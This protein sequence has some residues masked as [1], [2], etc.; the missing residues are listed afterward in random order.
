MNQI[1]LKPNEKKYLRI[2]AKKH[3][4][5]PTKYKK[6]LVKGWNKFYAETK[7]IEQLLTL[8]QEYSL[9]TG[10]WAG[11]D[12]YFIAIDLDD[13][14]AKERIDVSLY[15]TT[16]KGIHRYIFIKELPKSCFLVNQDGKKLGELHSAGRFV[17]G[18]GSVHQER[19]RYT[20]RGRVNEKWSLKFDK[21]T[22]LQN[23][24]KERSIF[25]TPWGKTGKEN[26]RDLE[27]YQPKSK[28]ATSQSNFY[29][30][31]QELETKITNH[32]KA[33]ELNICYTCLVYFRKDKEIIQTH[34]AGK[35]HQKNWKNYQNKQN[36][37]TETNKI[38]NICQLNQ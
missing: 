21:L 18:I 30:Q 37:T 25:I 24:L 6:P 28:K 4:L 27:L 17:V 32:P 19:T 35:K 9:R 13:Y 33:E 3:I 16:N 23:F 31:K 20:L 36:N 14:W 26:I 12:Y 22:E 1:K 38:T 10:K 7:T 8:N 34:L 11:G 15:I 29:Q 2:L 5:L